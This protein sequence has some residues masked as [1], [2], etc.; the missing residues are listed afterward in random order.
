MCCPALVSQAK[1]VYGLHAAS[2]RQLWKTETSAEIT[3]RSAVNEHGLIIIADLDGSVYGIG[4][5]PLLALRIVFGVCGAVALVCCA[6]CACH[7]CRRKPSAGAA[8]GARASLLPAKV[9]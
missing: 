6:V 1:T 9:R 2:G 5:V 7:T 3:A 8:A 4:G